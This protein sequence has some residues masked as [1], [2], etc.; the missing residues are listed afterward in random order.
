MLLVMT[1]MALVNQTVHRSELVLLV[2]AMQEDPGP[3][4]GGYH[5]HPEPVPSHTCCVKLS[6][7]ADQATVG[8]A[9]GRSRVVWSQHCQ[10][11]QLSSIPPT[12]HQGRK[13]EQRVSDSGP[14]SREPQEP[15]HQHLAFVWESQARKEANCCVGRRGQGQPGSH[16][17]SITRERRWWQGR[18]SSSRRNNSSPRGGEL[19]STK[20][21]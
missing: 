13:H 11:Q 5:P 20:L 18:S 17:I 21:G 15:P 3:W 2:A 6:R 14:A 8:T 1:R 16:S 4:P 7:G 9:R 12:S 19:F 10:Q